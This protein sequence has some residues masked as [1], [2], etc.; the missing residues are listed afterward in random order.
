[1]G[2]QL[3]DGDSKLPATISVTVAVGLVTPVAVGHAVATNTTSSASVSA[4]ALGRLI[5]RTRPVKRQRPA[6]G[7]SQRSDPGL[8]T[9]AIGVFRKSR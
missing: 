3:S 4:S 1:M 6:L 8:S 7:R 2:S 9:N 5:S